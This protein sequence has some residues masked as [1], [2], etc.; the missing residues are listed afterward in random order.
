MKNLKFILLFA[1]ILAITVHSCTKDK[2]MDLQNQTS[3]VSY[4]EQILNNIN[5]FKEKM[6]SNLKAEE[7]MHIDD[8]VW[9]LE[10][11][12]SYENA[13]PDSSSKDFQTYKSYYTLSVDNDSLAAES[14]IQ[15]VY[16]L[17]L[18]TVDYQLQEINATLKFLVF[19]DVK[20][21]EIV[22]GTAYI[23]ATNGFGFNLILG[24]YTPFGNDDDWIWGDNQGSCN[25][26]PLTELSDASDEIQYRLNHPEVQ[27]PGPGSYTDYETVV[28][29]TEECISEDDYFI[30][31]G[32][33]YFY[34]MENNELT[35]RLQ[36]G[37]SLIYNYNDLSNDTYGLLIIYED[38]GEGARPANKDFISIEITDENL[39]GNLFIHKYKITYAMPWSAPTN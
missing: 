3:E 20:L 32:S 33:N 34:C 25:S 27:F 16:Q 11:L 19:C 18:D 1:V 17:M 4:S 5:G 39:V 24:W 6:N 21:I 38:E 23:E 15:T 26:S 22:N 12:I 37:H 35:F 14:A 10:A 36:G 28:V 9:N 31:S 13:Y 8:A 2:S 29:T 7:K 30:Y